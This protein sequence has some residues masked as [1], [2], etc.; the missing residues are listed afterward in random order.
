[1]SPMSLASW[2]GSRGQGLRL[3]AMSGC[4]ACMITGHP[5]PLGYCSS[6]LKVTHCPMRADLSPRACQSR[7]RPLPCRRRPSGA[8]SLVSPRALASV[9]RLLRRL[10]RRPSLAALPALPF[11][12]G[13]G[14]RRIARLWERVT[15]A[16]LR[17]LVG[18]D[19]E[20]R[21]RHHLP[22]R[23]PGTDREQAS[24][25]LGDAGLPPAGA[26]HRDRPEA[27][28][29]P[30]P[31][32]RLVPDPGAAASASTAAVLPAP[33]A[34]WSRVPGPPWRRGLSVLIFPEGTRQAPGAPP[35]YKPGVAAL[36]AAL[37][38]PVV[39]V[40][41]NSGLWGRRSAVKRPGR[42]VVEFLE[43][44]PPGLDRESFMALLEERIETAT[45]RLVA[46]GAAGQAKAIPL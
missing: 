38:L 4:G 6:E 46:E 5:N 2:T 17:L 36:Y 43:P 1:M 15:L 14:T 29:H 44:I 33:C 28:A 41:L 21:G 35:D 8:S 32:A 9:Q 12:G 24:V 13:P 19:H 26:R 30:H 20:V 31:G 39:P 27:R 34:R 18:I 7:A 22:G 40:A 45:A 37:R 10:D 16:A 25:G 42:I 11:L 23:R 3:S